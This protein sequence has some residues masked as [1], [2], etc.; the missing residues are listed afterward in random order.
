M[1]ANTRYQ[2]SRMIARFVDYRVAHPNGT[3]GDSV[4]AFLLTLTPASGNTAWFALRAGLPDLDWRTVP[5]PRPRRDEA[6]LLATLLAPDEIPTIRRAMR[7]PMERAVL[8]LLWTL[9]RVET[10]RAR[11]SDV[12]LSDGT[13]RVVRKGGRVTWTLLRPE[14]QL[15]LAEWFI[16]AGQPPDTAYIFPGRFGGAMNPH[17]IG[18]LVRRVFRRAGLYRRWR[19]AHAFRRTLATRWMAQ[20]PGDSEGLAK[21]LGHT[22]V[23]TTYLYNYLGPDDLRPRLDRVRL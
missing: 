9:R 20:L 17:S 15:A 5:R 22:S 23:S 16:A 21:L 7:G 13:M 6:T 1:T 4:R 14:T 2:R 3:L 19:C 18:D 11:W 10:T 8:E 12:N